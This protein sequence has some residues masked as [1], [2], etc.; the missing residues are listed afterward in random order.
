MRVEQFN[1]NIYDIVISSNEY[2]IIGD[3][4]DVPRITEVE[5]TTEEK[6]IETK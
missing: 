5:E 6:V 4:G 3:E 1:E 2:K